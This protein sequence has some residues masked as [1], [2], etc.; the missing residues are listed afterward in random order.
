MIGPSLKISGAKRTQPKSLNQTV[1]LEIDASN[2]LGGDPRRSESSFPINL[3]CLAGD[4]L[5]KCQRDAT[6]VLVFYNQ[7]SLFW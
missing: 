3:S 5:A 1:K 7:W 4:R 6:Q 2:V